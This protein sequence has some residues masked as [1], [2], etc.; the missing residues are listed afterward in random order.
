MSE[1]VLPDLPP[2]PEPTDRAHT[3]DGWIE[4]PKGTRPA[5]ER[6]TA[7]LEHYRHVAAGNGTIVEIREA[8]SALENIGGQP[9]LG[10]CVR[11]D[12]EGL[13]V[14]ACPRSFNV[15]DADDPVPLVAKYPN[16]RARRSA[17]LGR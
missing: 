15:G 2:R 16:R 11:I 4:I 7:R 8:I 12:F 13:K 1:L 3:C 6:C 9:Q 14:W 5:C 17:R 10:E